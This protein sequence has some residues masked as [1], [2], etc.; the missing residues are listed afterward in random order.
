[1]YTFDAFAKD[2][3]SGAVLVYF[4]AFIVF[5]FIISV[6]KHLTKTIKKGECRARRG[7]WSTPLIPPLG[8]QISVSLRQTWPT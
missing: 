1:M 7:D 3:V 6:I 2:K 5:V 8:R 4:R